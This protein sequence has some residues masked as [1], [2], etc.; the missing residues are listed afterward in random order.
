MNDPAHQTDRELF[1][2]VSGGDSAALAELAR[3]HARGLY[4]F[5]L[6]GTLDEEQAASVVDSA[7][8]R[9]REPAA[10]VP[11][12]IDFRTWLY[13]L[14][15]V[16]IIEL[17]NEV[18]TAR[19]S[20]DDER[21]Y[22]VDS[23]VDRE[24]AHW[25]WQ[26][27]RGLRTRDYCVLDL[28]LRRGLTPEEVAEAASLTRSNLYA[29]IGRARGAFE[30][31]YAAMLLF[32]HGRN[33]CPELDE[34][35][36]NA[37]GNSLR[38]ALRHQIIEHSDD[39]EAC[40]RTLD[41]MPPAAEVYISL[42]DVEL[43]EAVRNRSLADATVTTPPTPEDDAVKPIVGSATSVAFATGSAELEA[44]TQA[45]AADFWGEPV[46][47]EPELIPATQEDIFGTE[48][49]EANGDGPPPPVAEPPVFEDPL[50]DEAVAEEESVEGVP[51]VV[52]VAEEP[53][54]AADAE[55]DAVTAEEAP[56][57]AIDVEE[58]PE[59]VEE[60]VV[61]PVPSLLVTRNGRPAAAATPVEEA[62]AEE[63]HASVGE[64]IGGLTGKQPLM[65]TYAL[66]GVLA[67]VAIFLGVAVANSLQTGGGDSG[68]LPLDAQSGV[69]GARQID[70]GDS[71]IEMD[72]G[73]STLISFDQSALDGYQIK[74]LSF[75]PASDNAKFEDLEATLEDPY[76]I[77]FAAKQQET[78][79]ERTEQFQLRIQWE[80][81][82]ESANSDCELVVH[83]KPQP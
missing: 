52:A 62:P 82:Q 48:S 46:A 12:Q 57:A 51:E 77:R 5:A 50:Q 79:E 8:R 31:T 33:A 7:F 32:E 66:L 41:G 47:P 80:R 30:E 74:T 55:E 35:V 53:E 81:G 23:S 60:A 40:R 42:T 27:A 2:A 38:P 72:A 44:R 9:I 22:Q 29:S 26:A 21:F 54:T 75:Q 18:R 61:S 67:V 39:C 28:T 70:C 73:T 63:E 16:E 71:P 45:P 36:E 24:I 59:A 83:V 25:A 58:E 76:S 10:D 11:S 4:D 6:R 34:M 19:I 3:R 14:C 56:E 49:E 37:P 65:W 15:L 43:P 13:S 20:T 17:A 64:R 69:A 78:A 1:G 68:A